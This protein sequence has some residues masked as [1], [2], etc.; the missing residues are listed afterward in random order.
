MT[1]ETEVSFEEA[2]DEVLHEDAEA[3]SLL[4]QT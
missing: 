4:A 2:L 1:T 3:I